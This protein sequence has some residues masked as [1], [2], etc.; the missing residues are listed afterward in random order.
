[1]VVPIALY[2]SHFQVL[3]NDYHEFNMES[4]EGLKAAVERHEGRRAAVKSETAMH[5]GG[6]A[7]VINIVICR[8]PLSHIPPSSIFLRHT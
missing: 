4:L 5:G 7:A 1:M 8:P 6:V 3:M 2:F